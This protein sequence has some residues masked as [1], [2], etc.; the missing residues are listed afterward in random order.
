[1]IEDKKCVDF[2]AHPV[3]DAFRAAMQEL[4][5]DP[6]EED[7]F[8]LPKWDV[9]EHL[10]FMDE[11]SID[12]AVL[13]APVPH[14]YNGDAEKAGKAARQITEETAKIVRLYPD[15]FAFAGLV[16]LPDV[17]GAL[18]ETAY[19]LDELGAA[20]LK[21]ATNMY[22]I[23]LGDPLF[24]P[25]MEE[26][27]RRKA[28]VIIH[29]CRARKRP[30]NV[31]TG[32]VAAI[33]E[34]PADTTRAVLNMISNRIMT[35]F[36]DIR[37]VVPHCGAFLPYMLQRFTGVSGILSSM[38]MMETVDVKAEFEKLYFD[39]AGDP[40]PVQLSMLRMVAADERIVYGSDFPHSPAKVV[41]AK[42][43]HFDGNKDYDEIREKIYSENAVRLLKGGANV[44]NI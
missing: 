41:L 7:G 4:R 33:Y 42:K 35:R 10:A 38:G 6:M 3:T 5:I 16:P 12:Y 20:G 1:M 23:Y 15:R 34:Y 21:V 19:A 31:I 14:I 30:E 25:V 43:K 26:W 36:P 39:I 8:P 17:E 9:Q 32:T 44:W 29:P 2:H 37:W 11:A 40:E 27:N 13:S 28:L 22:G 24:D 18:A